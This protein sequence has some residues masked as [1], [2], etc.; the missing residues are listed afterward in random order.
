[1]LCVAGGGGFFPGP[2]RGG[3]GGQP[4][5]RR[6]A[7][8]PS[9]APAEAVRGSP[10]AGLRGSRGGGGAAPSPG[11]RGPDIHLVRPRPRR[12]RAAGAPGEGRRPGAGRLA[13][14]RRGRL[15]LG[16]AKGVA[17]PREITKILSVFRIVRCAP[18]VPGSRG[19]R[20]V[21]LFPEM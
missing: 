4:A 14:P 7:D 2:G 8:R 18:G 6:A 5:A 10:A 9:W 1:M 13:G 11:G 15:A 20:A 3:A 21:W 16:A 12:R 19:A 17:V